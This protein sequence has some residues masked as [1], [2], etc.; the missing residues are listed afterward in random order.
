MIHRITSGLLFI[1]LL[2]TLSAIPADTSA[3]DQR[4]YKGGFGVKGGFIY[5]STVHIDDKVT[6]DKVGDYQSKAGVT[7][8]LFFDI[9]LHQRTMLGLDIDLYDIQIL[10]DRE[11]LFNLG[12]SVKHAFPKKHSRMAVRPGLGIGYGYL[13]EIGFVEQANMLMVRAFTEVLF[14]SDRKV[15]WLVEG[16]VVMTPYGRSLD[17]KISANPFLMLRGGARF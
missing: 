5:V 13:A 7:G 11:K 10:N 4:L 14:L 8:G 3:F 1:L 12:L 2:S 9:T 6:G 16:A 15:A 17:H